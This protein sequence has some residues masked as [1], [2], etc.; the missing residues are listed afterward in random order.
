MRWTLLAILGAVLAAVGIVGLGLEIAHG[1]DIWRRGNSGIA[2]LVV[3]GY[4][5]WYGLAERESGAR[6]K[7]LWPTLIWLAILFAIGVVLYVLAP[8]L[9][10]LYALL[11]GI[12]VRFSLVASWLERE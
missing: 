1:S 9:A 7:P 4:G 3:G 10:F 11:V 8:P 6:S 2:L 12:I 5:V